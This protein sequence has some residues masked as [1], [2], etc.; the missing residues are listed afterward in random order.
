[1]PLKPELDLFNTKASW[2]HIHTVTLRLSCF[3]V[4]AVSRFLVD[5]T[6]LGNSVSAR[7]EPNLCNIWAVVFTVMAKFSMAWGNKRLVNDASQMPLLGYRTAY[8]R[9]GGGSTDCGSTP[10][11]LRAPGSAGLYPRSHAGPTE[12]STS[13]SGKHYIVVGLTGHIH[14]YTFIYVSSPERYICYYVVA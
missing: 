5:W 10:G 8:S 2:A 6:S 13:Q 7:S 12:S 14:S 4:C 3:S 9:F 1:M 11:F